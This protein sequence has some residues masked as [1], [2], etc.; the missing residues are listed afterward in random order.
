[1]PQ[2]K[3]T[4]KAASNRRSR[5]LPSD[6]AAESALPVLAAPV[7]DVSAL[8]EILRA[9][10]EFEESSGSTRE[11]SPDGY[12]TLDEPDQVAAP[13][14]KIPQRERP[15]PVEAFAHDAAAF[16]EV[17]RALAAAE[18]CL[19]VLDDQT[20]LISMAVRD[21]MKA[22]MARAT[23]LLQLLRFLKGD[24]SPVQTTVSG[25]AV[26]QRAV[27]YVESERRLRG[28]ALTAN[29]SV[30]DVRFLGDEAL[31]ANVLFCL[32]LTAFIVL[33][34]VE[35][36]QV[37]LDVML[38]DGEMAI[39]VTQEPATPAHPWTQRGIGTPSKDDAAGVFSAV[40]MSVGQR[41]AHAWGGRFTADATGRSMSV[42]L[43]LPAVPGIQVASH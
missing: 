3:F 7:D 6:P 42:A 43:Q 27:Q 11:A 23:A 37:T 8:V 5:R 36:P 40:A 25:N 1:M 4:A 34:G 38:A 13:A 32:V 29:V 41:I 9:G 15:A 19:T 39:S 2:P 28:M 24:L 17:A 30:R 22:E 12:A 10:M 18:A 14:H 31:L 26:V 33:E 20:G 35:D 21:V 16:H